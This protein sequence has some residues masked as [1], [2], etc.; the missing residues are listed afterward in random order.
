[1]GSFPVQNVIDVP[2]LLVV[3]HAVIHLAGAL[4]RIHD[5]GDGVG[6]FQLPEVWDQRQLFCP[7]LPDHGRAAE[8]LLADDHIIQGSQLRDMD[9]GKILRQLKGNPEPGKVNGRP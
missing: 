9:A 4:V 7:A 8:N 3:P 2:C 5:K 1:M 6:G